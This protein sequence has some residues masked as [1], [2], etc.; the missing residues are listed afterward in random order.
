MQD[1]RTARN[2]RTT[3]TAMA[4]CGNGDSLVAD[5]TPA[6][7][8]EDGNDPEDTVLWRERD[9]ADADEAAAADVDAIEATTESAKVVSVNV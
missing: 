5:C 7:L 6:P 1:A 4:Q 3:M 8:V 9:A 2:P